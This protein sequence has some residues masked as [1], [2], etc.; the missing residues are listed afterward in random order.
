[1][2][3]QNYKRGNKKKKKNLYKHGSFKII[4]LSAMQDTPNVDAADMK[5]IILVENM[6]YFTIIDNL[7]KKKK[8]K[9]L[10]F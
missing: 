10:K 8:G 9:K 4:K 1:M 3:A 7:L 2:H 5:N 6:Y